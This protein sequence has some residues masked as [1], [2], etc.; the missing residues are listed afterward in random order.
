VDL[1]RVYFNLS[2]FILIRV[3]VPI[4]IGFQRVYDYV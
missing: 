1:K 4:I 2:T 3:I